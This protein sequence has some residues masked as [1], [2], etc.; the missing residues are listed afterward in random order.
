MM[1]KDNS[2]ELVV[3]A[4]DVCPKLAQLGMELDQGLL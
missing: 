2:S 3:I 1:L 4:I